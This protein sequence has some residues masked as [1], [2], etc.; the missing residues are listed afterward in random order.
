MQELLQESR[1]SR[2]EAAAAREGLEAA[3][4]EVQETV[5]TLTQK[6][7]AAKAEAA[8]WKQQAED[9][10]QALQAGGEGKD[11]QA[12]AHCLTGFKRMHNS[13]NQPQ[14]ADN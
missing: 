10:T 1:A 4:Q 12:C 14:L 7:E 11:Q 13:L 5:R 8:S 2:D 6:A 9:L 3:L